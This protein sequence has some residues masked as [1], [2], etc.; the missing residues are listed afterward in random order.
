MFLMFHLG[1]PDILPVGDLGVR[2]AIQLGYG[3]DELPKPAEM[4]TIAEPWRPYRSLASLYLW[5]SL[6]NAPD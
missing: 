4:V 1:R 2:R 6:D 3:L 5:S